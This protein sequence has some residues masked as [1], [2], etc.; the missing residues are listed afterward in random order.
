MRLPGG[1]LR[2]RDV[3]TLDDDGFLYLLDRTSDMI[4]TGGYN[5]YPREVEDVLLTHPA[6][7][8]CAVI[9]VADE[10][11]VEAVGAVVVTGPDANVSADELIAFCRDKLASYKKPRHVFFETALPKT[12][13]G[14]ISRKLLRDRYRDREAAATP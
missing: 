2:T 1:W 5:V 9:G 8:E 3:G 6:V 13:V 10:T 14:K 12:A 11:W 4:V 7:H